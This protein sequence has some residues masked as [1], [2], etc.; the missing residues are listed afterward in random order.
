MI[1]ELR[2]IRY[3][4]GLDDAAAKETELEVLRELYRAALRHALLDGVLTDA[5]K[6]KLTRA[7][8]TFGLAE[9]E[10]DA[11]Y[12]EEVHAVVQQAFNDAIKDRRLTADE[13]QRLMAMRA[14][15][16][17]TWTHDADT[18]KLVDRF[19]LLAKIESG[20][21]PPVAA[22]VRLQRGETCHAVFPSAL[23]EL[24]DSRSG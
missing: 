23:H 19:K 5:E 2:H 4:L 3:V 15:L 9:A 24:D 8:A 22:P 21:L 18:Q 12:K 13:E 16:D 10:R 7:S 11:F 6:E 20:D 1:S 17:V 14:N